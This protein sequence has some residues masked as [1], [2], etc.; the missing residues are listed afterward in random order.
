MSGAK[1]LPS[2]AFD[3]V[4]SHLYT[5]SLEDAL[6][7]FEGDMTLAFA[8]DIVH[9]S[10]E[11]CSMDRA[12]LRWLA[13]SQRRISAQYT[14][15][16]S[17]IKK[18]HDLSDEKMIKRM[19]PVAAV[20]KRKADRAFVITFLNRTFARM[21]EMMCEDKKTLERAIMMAIASYKR[22]V[23]EGIYDFTVMDE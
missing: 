6:R 2:P 14:G 10:T 12:I 20:M 23:E 5:P 4:P 22:R 16:Y 13:S 8:A 18:A 9:Q 15:L 21:V 17:A 3:W 1:L 19:E 11:G 7:G